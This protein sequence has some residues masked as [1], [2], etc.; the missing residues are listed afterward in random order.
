[1]AKGRGKPVIDATMLVM[2]GLLAAL[3]VLAGLRGGG[4]FVSRGFGDGANL[5]LRFAPLIVVSFLTA[6]FAELLIPQEWVRQR[7]GEESGIS[8]ILIGVGAGII[9]PSGPFVSLPIAAVL[10]RSGAGIGPVVAFIAGWSL[11]AVH[12]LVAWEIPILGP[13]IALQRYAVCLI[14]P[15]VAG[16]IARAFARL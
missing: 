3:A 13:R 9:T 11:L 10:L 4:E 12:R 14:L 15:I 7:L 1:M 5:L 16:L 2:L 6:G 8:G